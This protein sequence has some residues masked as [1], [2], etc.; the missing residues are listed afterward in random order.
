MN[1]LSKSLIV[2]FLA[3][4]LGSNFSVFPAQA[5]NN[6]LVL[7]AVKKCDIQ[8]S[9][10]SCVAEL[11]LTNNTGKVLDGEAF[12]HID[13]KGVCSS[14]QLRN[15]NGEGIKAQFFTANDNWLD[16]SDVWQNGTTTISDFEIAKEETQPKIRIETVPGLCPGEHSFT[17]KI[18][19]TAEDK[20]YPATTRIP[21]NVIS[22]TTT[23]ATIPP[24]TTTIFPTTTTIISP[25]TTTTIPGQVAGEV[26]KR[27]FFEEGEEGLPGTTTTTFPGLVFGKS[28]I[29]ESS[30]PVNLT[31]SGINPLLASLLCLGQGM[32]DSCLN[33]WL[34]LL[35]GLTIT[36]GSAILVK[37]DYE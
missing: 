16:F 8:H 2:L 3:F 11:K 34:V 7:E 5:Q 21:G 31:M 6:N 29:R 4:L 35:L 10:D 26:T 24:T 19:G 17:L 12:L 9:G 28:I 37:K 13:Y 33:P 27:E 20:I 15:F 22:P 1:K 30:C 25:I 14:N 18:V 36:L 23:T 32:C